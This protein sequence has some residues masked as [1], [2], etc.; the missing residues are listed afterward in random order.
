MSETM[1][2]KLH[3]AIFETT[4]IVLF[5]AHL[6][7]IVFYKRPFIWLN[8]Q[9]GRYWTCYHCINRELEYFSRPVVQQ[10]AAARGTHA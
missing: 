2:A 1:L 7:E 9:A 3:L 4:I 8:E 5:K 10:Q 6:N